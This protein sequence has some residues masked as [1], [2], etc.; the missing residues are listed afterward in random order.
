[1]AFEYNA[2]EILHKRKGESVDIWNIKW[3]DFENFS[4]HNH[5]GL[6]FIYY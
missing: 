5:Y 6:Y 1:M 4:Q 2:F 3:N